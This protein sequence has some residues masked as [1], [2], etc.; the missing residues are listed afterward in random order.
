MA[1]KAAPN[2]LRRRWRRH[3]AVARQEAEKS[4]AAP[5]QGRDIGLPSTRVEQAGVKQIA[6]GRPVKMSWSRNRA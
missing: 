5:P 1:A 2:A 3:Q 4:A 6:T